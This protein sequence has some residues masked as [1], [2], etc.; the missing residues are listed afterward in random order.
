MFK[1]FSIFAA[2]SG[3]ALVS[4]GTARA[5]PSDFSI[6]DGLSGVALGLCRAGVVVG[7][8]DEPPTGSMTACMEIEDNY[9]MTTGGPVPWTP[10]P[11][12]P[13]DYSLVPMDPVAW[14]SADG[15][16]IINYECPLFPGVTGFSASDGRPAFLTPPR[17]VTLHNGVEGSC[18]RI[19]ADGNAALLDATFDQALAC[20][21]DIIDY[22]TTFIAANPLV[23]VLDL[24]TGI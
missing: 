3:L 11:E 24:C 8:A 13:C 10:L 9:E 16:L 1:F 21:L 2:L 7:C 18:F 12:C 14:Q 6:C 4:T 5:E 22:A 15:F 23:P 19:D 20:R 17:M